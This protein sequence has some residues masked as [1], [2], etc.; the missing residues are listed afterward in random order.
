MRLNLISLAV[1]LTLKSINAS[2]IYLLPS[3]PL[4]S[5][6]VISRLWYR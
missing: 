4:S 1:G 5:S 6:V 3:T 2:P